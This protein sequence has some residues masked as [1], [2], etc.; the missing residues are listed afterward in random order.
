MLQLR[1]CP[2]L[3]YLT[4]DKPYP[5][6]EILAHTPRL[7]PGYFGDEAATEKSFITYVAVA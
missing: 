1:D 6:G 4:S 3:G 7:S 5:R 2:E